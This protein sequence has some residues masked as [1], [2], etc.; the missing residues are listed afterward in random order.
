MPTMKNIGRELYAM[1]SQLL[2]QRQSHLDAV[3]EI[4]AVLGEL[5]ISAPQARRGKV[6]AVKAGVPAVGRRRT[7]RV[8]KVTGEQLIINFVKAAGKNG[9]TG[10]QIN[11]HWKAEGRS[12]AAYTPLTKLVKEGRIKRHKIRNG[13]GSRYTA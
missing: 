3:A 2:S 4:D 13:R 9:A 8:F 12:G 6:R 1:L 7:R 10:A 11:K 5:G